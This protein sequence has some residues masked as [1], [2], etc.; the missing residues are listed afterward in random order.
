MIG[1]FD[2]D[3]WS[4]IVAIAGVVLLALG[5]LVMS[6]P[7]V[8]PDLEEAPPSRRAPI[9]TAKDLWGR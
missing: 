7:P 9:F 4:L 6:S 3:Q 8:T 5:N 2:L 1:P